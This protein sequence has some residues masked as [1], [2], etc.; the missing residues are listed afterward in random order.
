MTQLSATERRWGWCFFAVQMLIL[1]SLVNQIALWLPWSFGSA[2]VNFSYHLVS[3]LAISLIFR[4]FLSKN[5]HSAAAHPVKL[6]LTV[7]LSLGAYYAAQEG[8]TAL[9]RCIDPGFFNVNDETIVAMRRGNVVLTALATVLL[10]P[11]TEECIYRG[12]V[13]GTARRHGNKFAYAL[14]AAVFASVHVVGY[15]GQYSAGQLGLCFVQY[16]P[17]G[18]ILAAGFQFSGTLTA[19]ILTHMIINTISMVNIL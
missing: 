8:M 19:P 14:S 9:I 3:F 18:L 15:V 16:L 4:R 13:F 6:L 10:A 7:A 17:A 11:V 2:E 5:L 12:L 1:P